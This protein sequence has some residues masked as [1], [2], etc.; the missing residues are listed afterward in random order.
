MTARETFVNSFLFPVKLQ[1]GTD[2]IVSIDLPNLA[3]R[4][5]IG[6]YQELCDLLLSNHQTFLFEVRLNQ[7]VFCTEPL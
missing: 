1:F 6:D 2:T 3:P 4:L 7:Y 5:H